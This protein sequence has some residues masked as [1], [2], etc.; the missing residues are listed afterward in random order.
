[1]KL[2]TFLNRQICE[3]RYQFDSLNLRSKEDKGLFFQELHELIATNLKMMNSTIKKAIETYFKENFKKEW[4]PLEETFSQELNYQLKLYNRLIDYIINNRYEIIT[5]N[6]YYT[7]NFDEGVSG[8]VDLI[9][10]K[11]GKYEAIRIKRGEPKF[12]YKARKDINKV[13]NSLEL[14]IMKLGLEPS[15]PGI[16]CSLFYVESKD[17][18]M[19]DVIPIYEIKQGKN[20]V[21]SS[22]EGETLDSLKARI[23]DVMQLK[24]EKNCDY[25][26]YKELCSRKEYAIPQKKEVHKEHKAIQFSKK[27][28]VV[29]NHLYGSMR[30]VAGPGSGKTAVLVERLVTLINKGISPKNILFLTFTNKA[31]EEIIERVKTRIGEENLPT[32]KTFNGLGYEIIRRHKDLLKRDKII[33]ATKIDRYNIIIDCLKRISIPGLSYANIYS[34]FG[35][36]PKLDKMIEKMRIMGYHKNSS[37]TPF[38]KAMVLEQLGI[39]EEPLDAFMRLFCLYLKMFE[40]RGYIHYDEQIKLCNEL[41][42]AFPEIKN[43][44]I[45]IYQYIMVDEFQDVD[46][47]QDKFITHLAYHG[48]IVIVGD[49]DQSIYGFRNGSN[50]YML[51]FHKKFACKDVIL[52]DNYRST[53]SILALSNKLIKNNSRRFNKSRVGNRAKGVEPK[54]LVES[55]DEDLLKEVRELLKSYSPA[56]IAILARSNSDLYKIADLFLEN[57]IDCLSPKNYLINT[58]MFRGIYDFISLF[59]N[60][61]DDLTLYHV[62]SRFYHFEDV[63]LKD[64][65][66]NQS[67]FKYLLR[68]NNEHLGELM[69]DIFSI[70]NCINSDVKTAVI[71][72]AEK[73]FNTTEDPVLETILDLIDEKSLS[74]GEL[75]QLMG[76]MILFEDDT[77][78]Q[79]EQ[80]G[81]KINLFTAHD[82]KGKEFKVVIVAKANKFEKG[83]SK[84]EEEEERR[85]LYVALTRAEELLYILADKAKKKEDSSFLQELLQC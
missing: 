72:I 61:D 67:L 42:S 44:Y 9:A 14:L 21:S 39:E 22:F 52:S 56:D 63:M 47:Q 7:A 38:E 84:E 30:V 48:N 69:Q 5:A 3:K 45:K 32:I 18:T 50:E 60:M 29:I 55:S 1:M 20:I 13:E 6:Q 40:E 35:L 58:P 2:R 33:V 49:D 16:T 17:D 81:N 64:K 34:S 83:N 70:V 37:I 41:F 76:D 71:R 27:Q 75:Y 53:D 31:C 77:R 59:K 10:S 68:I 51:G 78:I 43:Q 36:I 62:L 46:E 54:I 73:L 79:E 15:Y 57:G 80:D 11:D 4:F 12:S 82:S 85:L 74:F 28:Q 19:R 24:Q 25:C 26:S 65:V 23:H 66:K 8:K